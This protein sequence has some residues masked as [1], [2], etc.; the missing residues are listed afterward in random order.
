MK[1]I[2]ALATALL[3]TFTLAQQPQRPSDEEMNARIQ[4]LSAQRNNALDQVVVLS[5]QAH[6]ELGKLQ[7]EVER[8]KK[9]AAACAPKKEPEK[10]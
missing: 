2:V 10:K 7:A 4:A 1:R 3:S 9:E 5:G 8:L 6:A